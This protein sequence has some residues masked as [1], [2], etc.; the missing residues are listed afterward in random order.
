MIRKLS[1]LMCFACM[2][3]GASTLGTID[4]TSVSG[5]TGTAP[6]AGI[7]VGYDFADVISG[8]GP[9]LGNIAVLCDD[10]TDETSFPSGPFD[11]SESTFSNPT[12]LSISTSGMNLKFTSGYYDPSSI[13]SQL[14]A[15]E[16]AAILLYNYNG[17]YSNGPGKDPNYNTDTAAYGLAL[18]GLFD[19]SLL[20]GAL[21]TLQTAA[22]NYLTAAMTQQAKGVGAN[23]AAYSGLVV[24]TATDTSNQEFL[25]YVSDTPARTPEPASLSVFGLALFGLGILCWRRA[26]R[27][28]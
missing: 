25:T 6:I 26:S 24:L 10:F 15:Y 3:A 19:P 11:Y 20:A 16:V 17:L 5:L 27:V 14:A 9:A 7:Y 1:I 4:F 18:W 8:T 22:V 13:T 23:S 28:A 21:N 12:L 2:V